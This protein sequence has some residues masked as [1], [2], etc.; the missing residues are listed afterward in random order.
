MDVITDRAHARFDNR[1]ADVDAGII[2]LI[3]LASNTLSYV[4][5]HRSQRAVD[6][7]V[8][9]FGPTIRI[10]VVCSRQLEHGPR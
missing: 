1:S 6:M 10:Y 4:Q 9:R 3:M 8:V 2:L 7:L 5:T